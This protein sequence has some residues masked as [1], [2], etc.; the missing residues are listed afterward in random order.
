MGEKRG[1]VERGYA[2]EERQKATNSGKCAVEFETVLAS[3]K[4]IQS[5][6]PAL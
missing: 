4:A 1:S 6:R 5:E 3:T 2:A